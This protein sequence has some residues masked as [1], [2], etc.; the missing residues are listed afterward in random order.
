MQE[1]QLGMRVDKWL[2]AA[3]FFKTRALAREAVELGRVR[4]SGERMKPSREIRPGD[5]LQIDRAE[6]RFDVHVLKLSEFRGP[7]PV[8]RELYEETEESR[9]RRERIAA[10]KRYAEEPAQSIRKGRPT[11]RDAR[12]IRAIKYG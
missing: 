3:R 7:A 9:E 6:E 10:N 11:K 1:E 4:I 12:A 8:A 2:W 5:R